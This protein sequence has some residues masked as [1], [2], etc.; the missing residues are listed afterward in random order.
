MASLLRYRNK[1]K[2]IKMINKKVALRG[3][4]DS[5]GNLEDL[6]DFMKNPQLIYSKKNV[7]ELDMKLQETGQLQR[8]YIDDIGVNQR[9]K[10]APTNDIDSIKTAN[11]KALEF[12]NM[13]SP[14]PSLVSDTKNLE[15]LV[16]MR[17]K[18][19]RDVRRRM[20]VR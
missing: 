15:E 4:R 20:R 6:N 5:M 18:K 13:L 9:I 8:E 3:F 7:Q 10:D 2:T 16:A 1:D 12:D 11:A 14:D 17:K 19:M